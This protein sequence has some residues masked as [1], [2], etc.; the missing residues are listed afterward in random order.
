VG[1]NNAR[2]LLAGATGLVGSQVLKTLL[3]D[4]D[5]R[6]RIVAPVRRPITPSDPRL[7]T[8]VGPLPSPTLETEVPALDVFVSCLGTTLKAAGSREAFIAVDRE[9]VLQLAQLA[10]RRGAKRCI[11]V[12]SVGA[13][14]Q[15]GNFYL[16]IK[17]E[18]E[19]A[20]EAMA[21][22]RIDIVRP[23]LL[24]GERPD[25]RPAEAWAQRIAP[26]LNPLLIGRLAGY[27]SIRSAQVANAVARL[28][29]E[30]S[31]GH[32]VHGYAELVAPG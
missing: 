13:S 15:S 31:P 3:A 20:L 22:D 10:L 25:R 4:R 2:I 28:T 29:A 24:L 1:V 18:V 21:F 27:R 26:L 7:A 5:F 11:V 23:G 8:I 32:F 12:S 19:D 14:R 6:G 9:L 16:R 17:G 30:T